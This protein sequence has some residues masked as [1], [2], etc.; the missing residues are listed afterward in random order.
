MQGILQLLTQLQCAQVH[1]FQSFPLFQQCWHF[2]KRSLVLHI[3]PSPPAVYTRVLFFPGNNEDEYF[4]IGISPR[5]RPVQDTTTVEL[6]QRPDHADLTADGGS[7]VVKRIVG[8]AKAQK[9]HT[10]GGR[11]AGRARSK[12]KPPVVRLS[13]F[14]ATAAIQRQVFH[15]LKIESGQKEVEVAVD[16]TT[17]G[18][19]VTQSVS[20]SQHI[21]LFFVKLLQNHAF[22][23]K[24][25]M[26]L[27]PKAT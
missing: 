22:F 23:F 1:I 27:G 4:S 3:F 15:S 11:G 9:Y 21:L 10:L 25:D 20:R 8:D 5:R 24:T 13:T 19:N 14:G 16:T 26:T 7:S 18:T 17:D 2:L 12:A 6:R